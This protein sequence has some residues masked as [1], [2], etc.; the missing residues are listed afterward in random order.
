MARTGRQTT[1]GLTAA[2]L[3]LS[4]TG[5]GSQSLRTTRP[6]APPAAAPYP[7]QSTYGQPSYG[8]PVPGQPVPGQPTLPIGYVPTPYGPGIP[9][10][11][12]PT[13]GTPPST[14][15]KQPGTPTGPIAHPTPEPGQAP[16]NS[17]ESWSPWPLP[18]ANKLMAEQDAAPH[19]QRSVAATGM[20]LAGGVNKDSG[21]G[22]TPIGFEFASASETAARQLRYRGGH[23][24]RDLQYVNLFLGGEDA[25][26]RADI[27]DIENS[28]SAAMRDAHLNNVLRQYFDN[29]PISSTAHPPHP[30]VG[31]VPEKV[32]RGDIEHYLL[33]LERLGYLRAYDRNDTVF[34]IL[35][36]SGTILSDRASASHTKP[37]SELSSIATGAAAAD[38]VDSTQGLA[39]YH[40]SVVAADGSRLYFS[41]AVFS[42]QTGLGQ[43]NGIPVFAESWKNVAA[44]LYHQLI[45]TRTD[46]DVEDALR[47]STDLETDGYLGWVSDGGLEVGDVLADAGVP[48]TSVIREVPLADGSGSVPVQLPYSNLAGGVEG[49]I[50][51]PHGQPSPR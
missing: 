12:N 28:V 34:N 39:G 13:P 21:S 42:E 32:T 45:E 51:E 16:D 37:P 50:A 35:L 38:A 17:D 47:S 5:C 24:I 40:G 1:L 46:P 44:T 2:L 14:P 15:G 8:Q 23:L 11:M 19:P 36:P 9:I 31:Y 30:L 6:F 3:L 7:G 10:V 33:H 29:Q 4:L 43:T 18:P 48:L 41:V 22:V 25:W 20:M 49:P 27:E 26:S